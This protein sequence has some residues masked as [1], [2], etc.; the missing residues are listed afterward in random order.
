MADTARDRFFE[1]DEV[2]GLLAQLPALELAKLREVSAHLRLAVDAFT[3]ELIATRNLRP[4]GRAHSRLQE[5]DR[6]ERA[7]FHEDFGAGWR[8][9]WRDGPTAQDAKHELHGIRYEHIE[10][11]PELSSGCGQGVSSGCGQ[12]AVGAGGGSAGVWSG[13]PFG[14]A[15]CGERGG[16]FVG[17]AGGGSGGPSSLGGADGEASGCGGAASRAAREGSLYYL[18]N[19]TNNSH[20]LHYSVAGPL[21]SSSP[22][23]EASELIES[24]PRHFVSLRGGGPMN[25]N[26]LFRAFDSPLRPRKITFCTRVVARCNCRAFANVFFSSGPVAYGET[27]EVFF[28]FFFFFVNVYNNIPRFLQI[29]APYS[30]LSRILM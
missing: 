4:R 22:M 23:G 10:V 7:L 21:S 17:G 12:L 9:R 3:A 6:M 8:V 13:G 16:P 25:F 2:L 28:F 11:R 14:G 26:G 1:G 24:L 29:C 19:T 27:E 18:N 5:M 15:A 20:S 30:S